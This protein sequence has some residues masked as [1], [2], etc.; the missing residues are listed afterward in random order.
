M[1]KKILEKEKRKKL[2]ALLHGVGSKHK[3]EF[4]CLNCRHSFS[5]Q[6]INLNLMEKF[7]KLK[8]A[9]KF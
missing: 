7:V 9:V 6:K 5:K 2:F 8:I 3:G 1:K 4:Y